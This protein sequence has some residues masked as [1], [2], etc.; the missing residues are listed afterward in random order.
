MLGAIT[1]LTNHSQRTTEI[2]LK[3]RTQQIL[4]LCIMLLL[5]GIGVC[6]KPDMPQYYLYLMLALF[7]GIT[8]LFKVTFGIRCSVDA[9]SHGGIAVCYFQEP[10]I[11]LLY[12]TVM[13]TLGFRLLRAL[14]GL[15]GLLTVILHFAI[16]VCQ[17][18]EPTLCTL[19]VGLALALTIEFISQ[20]HRDGDH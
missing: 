2:S 1:M 18:Q 3:S 15:G 12:I 10:V 9:V 17:L 5:V 11:F 8:E 13:I 20:S 14:R 19:Y 16:A 6:H 4:E 7:V